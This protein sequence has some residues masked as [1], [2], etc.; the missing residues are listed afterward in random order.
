[1]L[2]ACVVGI[3][4]CKSA[5]VHAP[6]RS[7][8]L[9]IHQY[10]PQPTGRG[11][12]DSTVTETQILAPSDSRLLYDGVRVLAGLLAEA[13][14][15]RRGHDTLAVAL[16]ATPALPRRRRGGHLPAEA[17]LRPRQGPAG[18]SAPETAQTPAGSKKNRLP[19]TRS[20]TIGRNRQTKKDQKTEFTD[21]N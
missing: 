5:P 2:G 6:G 17:P 21:K 10:S 16:R 11:R 3:H 4:G 15:E 9:H 20:P 18:R 12:G 8:S 19:D 1:M 7:I 13:R 14:A